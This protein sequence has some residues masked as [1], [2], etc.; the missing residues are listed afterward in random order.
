MIDE[1]PT[2][3][4]RTHT[5]ISREAVDRWLYRQA[6]A[7]GDMTNAEV[8]ALAMKHSRGKADPT[9]VRAALDDLH[10]HSCADWDWMI[11]TKNFPEYECCT[12]VKP[13]AP[14]SR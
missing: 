11:I 8:I 7:I 3:P 5:P 10:R 9:M 6:G 2:Y 1:F 12:C 4:G 14:T 13:D